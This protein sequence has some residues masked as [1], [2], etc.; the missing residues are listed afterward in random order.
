[1]VKMDLSFYKGKKVLITGHTGFKGSWLC[2]I[3][4]KLGAEV[5][6]IGLYPDTDPSLFQILGLES[7]IE[8]H[9]LD[10]REYGAVKEIF[11]TFKP[12]IVLHLAAQ[13][14]VIES[15]RDPR[16]TYEVNVMGTVN[17]C[18]CVRSSKSVKSFIN[19][20]TDK[21]Y[22]NIEDPSH[23]YREDE[24]LNGYDP[25]SNSKSCSDLITQAYIRSF[26]KDGTIAVSICRAG[27]VIGGG[28]YADNRI[29]PD[30]VRAAMSHQAVQ[31]RNPNSYRPY[32]HVLE[33]DVFYLMLAM[34]QYEDPCL[35]GF[36]NIGPDDKDCISTGQLVRMF[37][38][39][40]P[41]AEYEIASSDGP[42][43][44]NFLKLDSSKARKE[45]LWHPVWNVEYAVRK[46]VE[47]Y[48]AFSMQ[49]DMD[50]VTDRQISEYLEQ[51]YE[52]E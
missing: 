42:H 38:E 43:E 23:Y 3:L 11:D 17:I 21:V 6:G 7:K 46:T 9:Y 10:I 28:D 37:T 47:W 8:N 30:C 50:V 2:Q 26:Y 36:Y 44:A 15:Y 13:P 16:Y 49:E 52:M 14:L 25:Y 24:K 31:I 32:Q 18:E 12:E 19:V 45:L 33:A 41:Q 29:I 51:C 20:T 27:N 1:M 40:W 35:A 39:N 48:R 22:E 5:C 4:L 34:K